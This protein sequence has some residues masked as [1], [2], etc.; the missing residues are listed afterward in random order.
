MNRGDSENSSSAESKK[1]PDTTDR[2]KA[3]HLRCERQRREAINNG[4]QELK[5]L[6]PASFSS[7]GCKTTNALILFRAADYLNQL[8]A[9][10]DNTQSKLTQLLA[11]VQALELIAAQ[12]E[13][14]SAETSVANKSSL[15]CR[16]VQTLLDACYTSFC[17]QVDVS[18]LQSVTQ[19]LLPW[20]ENLDYDVGL[21]C[22]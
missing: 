15:Q 10:V 21:A 5:E 13:N 22:L 2:K 4:Y 17:R 7:I 19:T 16:M 6:L 9:D 12:Y 1:S 18:T 3:T 14:M 20:V 11:Q 8:K